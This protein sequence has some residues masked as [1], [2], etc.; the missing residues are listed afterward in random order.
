MDK[1]GLSHPR[2]VCVHA[3]CF[4]MVI[5]LDLP[6]DPRVR[7]LI[8]VTSVMTTNLYTF[9]KNTYKKV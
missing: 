3:L 1:T 9:K 5:L 6:Y 2:H 7:V 8:T 4:G